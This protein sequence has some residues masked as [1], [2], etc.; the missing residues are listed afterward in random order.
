MKTLVPNADIE[1]VL[2]HERRYLHTFFSKLAEADIVFVRELERYTA[3]ELFEIA[4]TSQANQDR[5]MKYVNAGYLE[6]RPS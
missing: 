5:F 4:P 6:L 3:K 2:R 1:S